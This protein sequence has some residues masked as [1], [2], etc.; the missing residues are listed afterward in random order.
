M[1]DKVIAGFEPLLE[2]VQAFAYPLAF[3]MFSLGFYIVMTG[4]KNKGIEIIKWTAIGF[5]GSQFIPSIMRMLMDIGV[6]L[7][8]GF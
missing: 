1:I 5:V 3:L 6:A 4:N 8:A 2:L 7:K